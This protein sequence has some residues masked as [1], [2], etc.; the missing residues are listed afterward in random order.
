MFFTNYN[1][2][3]KEVP[4]MINKWYIEYEDAFFFSTLWVWYVN[5]QYY[6]SSNIRV[7]IYWYLS[8]MLW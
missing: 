1:L 7:K 5:C 6:I 2:V 4:S 8:H 3:F